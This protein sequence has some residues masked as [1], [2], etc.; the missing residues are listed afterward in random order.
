[1][2]KVFEEPGSDAFAGLDLRSLR[3]DHAWL[4]VTSAVDRG[5]WLYA[6]SD[7]CYRVSPPSPPTN[8]TR[9]I[10]SALFTPPPP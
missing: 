1:M 6:R 9:A 4:V 8:W 2:A 3:I 7:D 10:A 5:A